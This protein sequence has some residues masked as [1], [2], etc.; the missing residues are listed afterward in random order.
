M[1]QIRVS[2]SQWRPRIPVNTGSRKAVT[3]AAA[4]S[5]VASE[6]SKSARHRS[7]DTEVLTPRVAYLRAHLATTESRTFRR[8]VV[9]LTDLIVWAGDSGIDG[10]GRTHPGF[11]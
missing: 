4:S 8:A 2:G 6:R 10:G 9:D 7:L 1:I 5:G 11:R 3:D